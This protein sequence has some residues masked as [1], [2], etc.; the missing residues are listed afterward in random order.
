[1]RG[2]SATLSSLAP[3]DLD[4]TTEA[5]LQGQS[6]VEKSHEDNLQAELQFLMKQTRLWR[7]INSAQWVAW[8]I[9]QAKV[10]GME[11]AIAAAA[12]AKAPNGNGPSG[13]S[14]GSVVTAAEPPV[15][16][17]VDA[18][19]DEADEFDYLAYA[20]DRAMFFWAD[21][22]AL[23]LVREDELPPQ[24]VEHIKSRMIEY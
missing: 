4:S 20:Q 23:R 2:N 11:E 7:V 8:G 15:Q 13:G 17:P 21:L 9:V 14:T 1:M 24:M 10:P 12:A 5:D 18:D 6:E 16:P 19:V 3:L 22:L